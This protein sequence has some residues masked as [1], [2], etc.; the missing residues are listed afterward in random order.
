VKIMAQKSS[1]FIKIDNYREVLDLA[2]EL[3]Q[4]L[5]AVKE[6]Y[7]E[8]EDIRTEEQKELDMWKKHLQDIE[9]QLHEVDQTLFE[10]EQ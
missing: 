5:L 6:S 2:D 9:R 7:K 1:V 4:Q 3:K 8:L 10:P